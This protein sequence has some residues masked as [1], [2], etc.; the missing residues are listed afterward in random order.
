MNNTPAPELN[1]KDIRTVAYIMLAGV[2][3][4]IL[5]LFWAARSINAQEKVKEYKLTEVQ[6]LKLQVAQKDA[7]LLKAQI[8]ALQTKF[9]ERVTELMSTAQKYKLENGWPPET[10]F[11]PDTLTFSAPPVASKD[12]S[13][14]DD[15]AKVKNP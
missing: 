14:L 15:P 10:Q 5:C 6:Q 8:D 11:N 1:S 13:R 4:V 12:P 3:L 9:Q 2:I 7:L